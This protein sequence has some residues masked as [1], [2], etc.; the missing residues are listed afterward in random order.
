VAD[1]TDEQEAEYQDIKRQIAELTQESTPSSPSLQETE[2]PW[3]MADGGGPYYGP[4]NP[5]GADT[6]GL[7]GSIARGIYN[8]PKGAAAIGT[9]AIGAV[10]GALGTAAL[11]KNPFAIPAGMTA[12]EEVAN[13]FNQLVGLEEDRPAV[14]D[15]IYMTGRGALNYALPGQGSLWSI[16]A[17]RAAKKAAASK[18]AHDGIFLANELSYPKTLVPEEIINAN[19]LTQAV[20][21]IERS[22]LFQA[23]NTALDPATGK[24]ITPVDEASKQSLFGMTQ[25]LPDARSSVGEMI[26]VAGQNIDELARANGKPISISFDEIPTK[27]IEA[28]ATRLK[29]QP[30]L[31]GVGDEIL[32]TLNTYKQQFIKT[33][34]DRLGNPGNNFQS[35]VSLTEAQDMIKN[36]NLMEREAGAFD[37]STAGNVFRGNVKSKE[38]AELLKGQIGEF[39]RQLTDVVNAKSEAAL[40]S[41]PRTEA[42]KGYSPDHLS[43][44]NSLYG[45]LATLEP[46]MQR[47]TA[48]GQKGL[49]PKL[50]HSLLD[51]VGNAGSTP[52][53]ITG[54]VIRGGQKLLGGLAPSE[55]MKYLQRNAEILSN[56]QQNLLLRSRPLIPRQTEGVLTNLEAART[57]GFIL[58]N[59]GILDASAQDAIL[60]PEQVL[61]KRPPAIQEQLI[62]QA[63]TIAPDLFDPA[64]EGYQ[65]VF[66]GK[67]TDPFEKDLHLKGIIDSDLSPEQE[68]ELIM[69]LLSKNKYTPIPQRTQSMAPISQPTSD[70]DM[71]SFINDLDIPMFEQ[72]PGV[73]TSDPVQQ[74]ENMTKSRSRINFERSGL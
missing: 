37:V 11:T 22:G 42:T 74:L 15:A 17:S 47:A 44:L 39:R 63:A 6:G 46:A 29:A 61:Q 59:Q 69:P 8:D 14:E 52:Q 3:N 62:Q 7:A 40:S 24:F 25:G 49:L 4:T 31:S 56:I 45:S 58:R 71:N 19:R 2:P 57:V 16:P 41:F 1:W 28:F 30:E 48:S 12:G 72:E 67:F 35:S 38:Q 53:T 51:A 5:Y 55:Q 13:Q 60:P 32:H 64:P 33:N 21:T 68:A 65:S 50:D 9:R 73:F 10:G 54:G 26:G 18:V 36:L 66:N 34:A 27:Q 23:Q 70:F 20:P 43:Y